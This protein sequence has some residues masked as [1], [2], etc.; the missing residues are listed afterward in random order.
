MFHTGLCRAHAPFHRVSLS[1]V[2]VSRGCLSSSV[3]LV[4]AIALTANPSAM[5]AQRGGGGGRNSMPVICVHDCTV[6]EGLSSEDDLKNFHRVV[7]L[8]ATPEQRAAFTKIAQYTEAARD[9]LKAF[10]E[11]LRKVPASKSSTD[12][13]LADPGLAGQRAALDQA[14][15]SARAGSQNFLGSFSDAQKS[16]LKEITSKLAKADSELDSE[17]KT[18]D[19]NFRAEKPDSAQII[20]SSASL[21]KELDNFQSEQFALAREMGIL[22]GEDSQQ[23]T[24]NLPRITNSITFADQTLAIPASGEFP[25]PPLKTVTT[26]LDF[27]SRPTFRTCRRTSPKYSAPA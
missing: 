18:L 5:F 9:R 12:P 23:L 16:G 26:S 24:F 4:A 20:N 8:Q 13:A 19:Q 22:L 10:H 2:P 15:Q 11:S 21:D 27:S 25:E 1:I 17:L 7:A 3:L 14:I 6:R